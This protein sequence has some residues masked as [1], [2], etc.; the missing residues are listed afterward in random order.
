MKTISLRGGRELVPGQTPLICTPLTAS[1]LPALLEQAHT[2]LQYGADLVE[3]RLDFF[4]LLLDPPAMLDSLFALREIL[5]DCPILLTCRSAQ[6]G[7]AREID[8]ANALFDTLQVLCAS[9]QADLLDFECS[10]S[11][12]LFALARTLTTASG[13][14][15]IGSYHNFAATPSAA[16]LLAH[17]RAA[18]EAGADLAKIAV[19]PHT[20]SDVLRL[21]DATI[22]ADAQ[23]PIPVIGIS[24][25]ALGQISRYAAGFCRSVFSF[26]QA[27][28]ASAP[29]QI[30]CDNLR[31]IM[32]L[33]PTTNSKAEIP[34]S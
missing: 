28:D 13:M 7:G 32:Q 8:D 4:D 2:C 19:M 25:G 11:A 16:E 23:L 18:H 30:S 31:Q 6:E 20:H 21:M 10:A 1:D 14:K 34:S 5:E 12:A 22:Q 33:L 9:G 26:A 29:G 3:W 27:V 17:F 24:M 15:L